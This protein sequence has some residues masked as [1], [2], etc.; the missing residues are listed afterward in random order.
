[1]TWLGNAEKDELD[2]I[3]KMTGALSVENIDSQE[4]ERLSDCLRHP[5]RINSAGAGDFERSG[6]FTPFQVASILDYR[7]RHGDI[8]S[9]AELSFVDGFNTDAVQAFEPFISLDAGPGKK[10]R[11]RSS[12]DLQLRSAYSPDKEQYSY[13]VKYRVSTGGL[14]CS[15]AASRSLSAKVATPEYLSGNISYENAHMRLILGDFNARFG[16]G[17][18]MWNTAQIGG[19]TSPSAY[20]RKPSGVAPT[21]SYTGSSALTGAAGTFYFR[22]WRASAILTLTELKTLAVNIS[23]YLRYGHVAVTQCMT[24]SDLAT[25]DFRIP[26]MRTSADMSLCIRGVNMFSELAYD[27]VDV[28]VEAISGVDFRVGEGARIASL[29]KYLD[30]ECLAAISGECRV[31]KKSD[32]TFSMECGYDFHDEPAEVQIKTQVLWNYKVSEALLFRFR[33][34]ERIRNYDNRF[35]TDARLDCVYEKNGLYASMRLNLLNCVNV[36]CLGYVDGGYKGKALSTFLRFGLFAVDDWEDRIYVYE[37]DAPGNFNVPAY[38]GRGYW[39]AATLS[40]NVSRWCRTYLRASIKKPG[41]A[42]LKCQ[43]VLRF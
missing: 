43:C 9:L 15:L 2:A 41:K 10:G 33:L 11:E 7:S 42:E 21:F 39:A 13:G 12:H 26:Q 17:L 36:A 1:M 22:G 20:M 31:G 37:R 25:V 5:L 30:R 32:L 40:W 3:L 27:W 14:N 8:C 23:R 29:V 24:F 19:L 28:R 6:I 34:S 38:Y 35:K 16:Q 4:F 18:C